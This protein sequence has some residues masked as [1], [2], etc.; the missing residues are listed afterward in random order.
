MDKYDWLLCPVCKNKTRIKLRPDTI[1]TNFPLFCPK[2]KQET[3]LHVQEMHMSVI[4]EP[5]A[6]TQSR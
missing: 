4:N 1:L 6:K 3:L 2:C 5:D